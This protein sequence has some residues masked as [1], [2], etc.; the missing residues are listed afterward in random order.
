MEVLGQKL[1][2]PNSKDLVNGVEFVET[3]SIAALFF[4]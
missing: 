3:R 1:V 2:P 4:C